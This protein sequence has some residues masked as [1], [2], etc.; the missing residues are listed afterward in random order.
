MGQKKVRNKYGVNG[1]KHNTFEKEGKKERKNRK[2]EVMEEKQ[3]KG[4]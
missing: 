1:Q 2:K 3:D 4:K